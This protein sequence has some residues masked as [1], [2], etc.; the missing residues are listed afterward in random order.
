MLILSMVWGAVV[1]GA[2]TLG[3]GVAN[4]QQPQLK[5]VEL[6]SSISEPRDVEPALGVNLYQ[7]TTTTQPV[8]AFGYAQDTV[9]VGGLQRT[10]SPQQRL[11]E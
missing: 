4:F 1:S 5:G 7:N 6:N 2:L 8:A 9:R 11:G 3:V 10:Y